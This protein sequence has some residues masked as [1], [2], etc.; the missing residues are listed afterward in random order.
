[1]AHVLIVT[2]ATAGRVNV[3]CELVRRLGR[4]GHEATIAS[5]F[6]ISDGVAA[7]GLTFVALGAPAPSGSP[8]AVGE[9]PTVRRLI[10][11]LTRMRQ[12]PNRRGRSEARAD[13]LELGDFLE[14]V[15][16]LQPDLILIDIELPA[17][18]MAA[19]STD[20]PVA[21]TT[22]MLSLWKRPGLPPLHRDIVPGVGW[23]GHRVG[24]EW[25]WIRFRA[26]KR[27]RNL[28]QRITR[29]GEDQLSVLG[30]VAERTG[31]PL[32]REALKYH[33]LIP[34]VYR[35]LPV[36]EFNARELEFPHD[37]H[38]TVRYVGPVMDSRPD[39]GRIDRASSQDRERL[40]RIYERRG[41]NETDALI[42]ATSG[43]WHRGDDL[44]LFRSVIT[45]VRLRPEWDLV[46][47][48]GGR[49]GPEA[50][51]EVPANVHV[52]AWAPQV[53]VLEHADVS[54]NHAG[55][56]SINESV[57]AGVPMLVFPF[58]YGDTT[59]AAARVAFHGLGI[60]ADRQDAA[61][62][63]EEHIRSL[64]SAPDYRRRVAEMR[65]RFLV[66]ERDNR[67]IREIETLLR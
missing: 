25:A 51:G 63:I 18:L 58:G 22:T 43:A 64:L 62:V 4:A 8:D 54:I 60:V 5:P 36:L 53:S 52:M 31:F 55:V 61:A 56:N 26:W 27:M 48:L 6:D 17:H 40:Q 1:M 3:S 66:Y 65:E 23:R 39:K 45:A 50:L 44:D 16:D 10:S 12:V 21:L 14:T 42:Y 29:V 46:I 33:W 47:G 57:I 38:S 11:F 59:G 9:P 49:F 34:F 7:Q 32:R 19:R 2:S 24:I 20:V 30:I 67:A 41:R 28:R 13:E 15:H 35:T 37:P